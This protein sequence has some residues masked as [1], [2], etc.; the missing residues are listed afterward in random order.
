MATENVNQDG[1]EFVSFVTTADEGCIPPGHGD[2]DGIVV[3]PDAGAVNLWGI[4]EARLTSLD[5][6]LAM[7]AEGAGAGFDMA[8]FAAVVRP[9]VEQILTLASTG[10]AR[11]SLARF[12]DD[13]LRK[14]MR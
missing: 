14:S 8:D 7:F 5:K 4:A 9:Q 13:G 1:P 12:A 10:N 3:H 2:I 6:M 11:A